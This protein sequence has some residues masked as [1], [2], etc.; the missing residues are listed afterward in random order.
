MVVVLLVG[1]A[2]LDEIEVVIVE[3]EA[4]HSLFTQYNPE[5]HWEVSV[6]YP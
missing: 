4:V 1:I 2:V 3:L 5:Q 6:Q